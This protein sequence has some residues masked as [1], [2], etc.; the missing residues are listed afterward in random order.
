MIMNKQIK[1][2]MVFFTVYAA[3]GVVCI[4]IAAF[5]HLTSFQ[6]GLFSGLGAVLLVFGV[7]SL[8]RYG[9]IA[10]DTERAEEWLAMQNEERTA[11]IAQKARAWTFYVQLS[12]PQAAVQHASFDEEQNHVQTRRKYGRSL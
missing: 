1:N 8:I 4:L 11:F 12:S 5:A 7:A 3:V 9:R 2:K 10:R 6:S